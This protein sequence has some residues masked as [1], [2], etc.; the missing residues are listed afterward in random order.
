[1]AIIIM[2]IGDRSITIESEVMRQDG[3]VVH[4]YGGDF[5]IIGH[6]LFFSCLLRNVSLR[7]RTI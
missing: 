6:I 1:M 2:I 4:H 5:R 7:P 3:D